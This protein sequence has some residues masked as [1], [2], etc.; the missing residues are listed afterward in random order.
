MA[1]LWEPG[2]DYVSGDVVSYQVATG[3]SNP[4]SDW[5]PSL[6]P[7]LWGRTSDES[8]GDH[9]QPPNQPPPNQQMPPTHEQHHD[10]SFQ[11]HSDQEPAPGS[12]E[13]EKKA[14]W[15]GGK[16]KIGLDDGGGIAAGPL[17]GWIKHFVKKHG[18]PEDQAAGHI[19]WVNDARERTEQ[20]NRDGPRGPVTWVLTQGKDIPEYA[21]E[22]G[23]EH[24]WALYICRAFYDGG[25]QI[26]KVSGALEKGA[27]IGY[28]HKVHHLDTYE[29]LLGDM[30]GLRWV[31][32][33][34][35][36]NVSELH[37]YP[38]E[39]GHEHDGTP[40]YVVKAIYDGV[41]HP[42]KASATLD[43]AYIPYGGTEK[44]VKEYEVLCYNS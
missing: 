10:D 43:G 11:H 27:V 36:L 26:G 39:G 18:K 3:L 38:V 28:Q 32:A 2:M 4:I 34:G 19:A 1:R 12:A 17:A 31:P 30:H 20:Y 35:K 24:S 44:N 41:F 22:V 7:A 16:S 42:G 14:Y 9:K 25:K 29:I 15:H 40:L 8:D 23:K 5:T 21:I 13:P 33:H 37:H 6:T